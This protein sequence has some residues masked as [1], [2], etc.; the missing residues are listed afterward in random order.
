MPRMFGNLSIPPKLVALLAV[1]VAGLALLV[2]AG[3][4][5]EWGDRARAREEREVAAVAGQAVA[6]VHELQEER[7]RARPHRRPGARPGRGRGRRAPGPAG[8]GPGRGRPGPGDPGTSHG[9]PR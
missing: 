6:A 5:A 4:T 1:P 2:A 8:G 9:R 7:A 3:A